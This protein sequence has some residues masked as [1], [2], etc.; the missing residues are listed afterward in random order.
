MSASLMSLG[1]GHPFHF[2]SS[3]PMCSPGT[4]IAT[5]VD[6]AP[7][8]SI[9]APINLAQLAAESGAPAAPVVTMATLRRQRLDSCRRY[10]E[11]IY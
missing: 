11:S 6:R 9:V 4:T 7:M 2:G 1:G 8:S 5:I 10:G 3:R